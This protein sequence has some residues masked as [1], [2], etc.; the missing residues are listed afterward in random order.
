MS[1]SNTHTHTH[2]HT[3]TQMLNW[4]WRDM[5]CQKN[6]CGQGYMPHTCSSSF[7]L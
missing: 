5:L 6:W 2:T 7:Y 4:W 3:H 1:P